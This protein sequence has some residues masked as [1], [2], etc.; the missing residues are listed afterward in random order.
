MPLC[1]RA[2]GL[3]GRNRLEAL[4]QPPRSSMPQNTYGM[5][6]GCAATKAKPQALGTTLGATLIV[7]Q[8]GSGGLWVLPHDPNQQ[9]AQ[10]TDVTASTEIVL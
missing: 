5:V 1:R 4:D 2:P 9:V 10:G 8:R 6:A 3:R 7:R